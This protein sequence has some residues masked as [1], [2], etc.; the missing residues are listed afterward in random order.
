MAQE[1]ELAA[2][3]AADRASEYVELEAAARQALAE[4]PAERGK[5]LVKLR[6]ATREVHRR[7]FFPPAERDRAQAALRVLAERAEP[8]TP[9][10]SPGRVGTDGGER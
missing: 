8:G 9:A 1:R 6:R 4:P 5:A 7:D 10:P 3:M 2:A